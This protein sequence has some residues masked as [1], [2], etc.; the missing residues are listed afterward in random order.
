[1]K[2]NE[3]L[4]G[5]AYDIA[6]WMAAYGDAA[7][8]LDQLGNVTDT[9]T[10]KLRAA[11]IIALL[12]KG[13]PDIYY[14]NLMRS[15]RCRLTYLQRC[16]AAG[17]TT[18]H[19]QA[20]SRVGGFVDAVAAADFATA[21]QITGLSPVTWL[22]GHEYEDDF[23]YA[24]VLHGLIAAQPDTAHMQSLFERFA[25]ALDGRLDARL[26]VAKA[27]FARNQADFDAGIEALIAQH[28]ASVEAD[29]ARNKIEEPVMMAER[30]V[31]VEGLA[32]LRI[33]ERLGLTL[34][35]EYLYL[36]SLARVPMGAPFP[37]E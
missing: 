35:A 33:T 22:Q 9:V 10:A 21:R 16:R 30:Q 27:I 15:A 4:E 11:A 20:S 13:D 1:M 14:H 24:Q 3:Y 7:Y 5:L 6:F 12:S 17:R 29:K 23:C 34:Q 25:S 26:D 2:L 8:P 36:P 32:F 19:H 28:T 18:D 31:Y 37:G